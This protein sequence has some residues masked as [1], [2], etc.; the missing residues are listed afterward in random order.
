MFTKCIVLS[1]I[2]PWTM[3]LPIQSGESVNQPSDR[4]KDG[5]SNRSP[6]VT[7]IYMCPSKLNLNS[8]L[9]IT[10]PLR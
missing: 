2:G 6:S 3:G 1:L 5:I 4:R 10:G 7:Y 9:Y 8:E